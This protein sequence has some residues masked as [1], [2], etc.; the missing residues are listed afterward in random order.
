VVSVE[1]GKNDAG[2]TPT[3]KFI[4]NMGAMVA[5]IK[6]AGAPTASI[7]SLSN[8]GGRA[9]TAEQELAEFRVDVRV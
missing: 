7:T 5:R 3:D 6:E 9:A 8:Y 4:S 2:G 1:L